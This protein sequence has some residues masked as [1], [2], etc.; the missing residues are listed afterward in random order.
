MPEGS[1]PRTLEAARRISDEGVAKVVLLGDE[2]T[3]LDTAATLGVTIDDCTIVNP[4][5]G[6][7]V[8][9]YAEQ[10]AAARQAKHSMAKRAMRKPLYYGA[11]MVRAGD[12]DLMLAGIATPTRRVIEPAQLCIGLAPGVSLPSSFF[13]M[14]FQNMSPLIFADC[15]VNVDPTAEELADIAIA[16]A[17]SAA[18]LLDEPPRVALLSLSTKGSASHQ[19]VD[20]VRSA[21]EIVRERAPEVLIDGEL[22]ADAALIPEIAQIKA[23]GKS[24]VAGRANVL[25]F[26]D[27]DSGNIAYKLVQHLA[28]ASAIGPILQ[29]F[30]R[31]VA[32]VSRGASVDDIVA[33]A[34]IALAMG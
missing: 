27:L 28:Q 8:D 13:V 30:D 15:A 19:R 18:K 22:Q 32:D 3:L 9:S 33:T 10:Y 26:P 20:K 1:E 6:E 14:E 17:G 34:V 12:A 24:G 29:G 21:L 16:S 4:L 7:R 2:K 5:A 31:P 11:M 25:I 23:A